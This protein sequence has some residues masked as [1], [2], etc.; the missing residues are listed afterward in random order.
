MTGFLSLS[1]DLKGVL[2]VADSLKG[3]ILG[4]TLS[5]TVCTVLAGLLVVLVVVEVVVVEEVEEVMD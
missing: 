4:A 1:L 5:V 3:R 2:V